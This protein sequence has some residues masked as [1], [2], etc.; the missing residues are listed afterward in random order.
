M[1][2]LNINMKKAKP[3]IISIVLGTAILGSA[4][5]Y[6]SYTKYKAAEE[7]KISEE[8]MKSAAEKTDSLIIKIGKVTIDSGKAISK[9]EKSYEK[10]TDEEKA[11]VTEYD[12]LLSAKKDYDAL[13]S[14]KEEAERIS[15]EIDDIGDVTIDKK[16]QIQSLSGRYSALSDFGKSYVKNYDTLK[17]KEESLNAIIEEA[18]T[19]INDEV[20]SEKKAEDDKSSKSSKTKKAESKDAADTS[21]DVPA[22]SVESAKTETASTVSDTNGNSVT[23][24]NSNGAK[25]EDLGPDLGTAT[26][27]ADGT[28]QV[29]Y[30][31]GNVMTQNTDGS[32][33]LESPDGKYAVFDANG[34]IIDKNYEFDENSTLVIV[35]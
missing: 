13:V 15:S 35:N 10:L 18:N 31:N 24:D 11:L 25:T 3:V 29:K 22:K 17:E 26:T 6:K 2:K 12:V 32:T 19:E 34:V 27:Y 7:I 14:E 5:A 9:A 16:E 21:A 4:Y 1:K 23:I 20:A 8:K 30:A 33:R 28:V